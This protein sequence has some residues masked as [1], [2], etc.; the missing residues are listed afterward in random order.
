MGKGYQPSR[1]LDFPGCCFQLVWPENSDMPTNTHRL[2][3]W[4]ETKLYDLRLIDV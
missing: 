4:H 3:V 1:R 2:L